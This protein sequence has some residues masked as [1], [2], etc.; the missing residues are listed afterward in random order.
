M[1]MPNKQFQWLSIAALLFA[2]A[3]IVVSAPEVN[4]FEQDQSAP[5][6]GF[7]AP[8]FT[9]TTLSGERITL[10]DLR[11]EA[12][13]VNLWASWCAPC[14]AEMPAM[15]AVYD[16]YREQGFH[17]LAVNATNQDSLSAAQAFVEELGLSYPILLDINGEV[18]AM[19][20]L[21]ALPSSFFISPDGRI[22]EVIIGGPMAEALLSIRAEQLIAEI[23]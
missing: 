4:S 16:R 1:C 6:K 5:T 18:S 15:Q 8:D 17:V 13:L 22:R 23:P 7:L 14:L 20:Q 2:A 11:G 10:S 19:Y 21:R 3:W 9:L 12:V